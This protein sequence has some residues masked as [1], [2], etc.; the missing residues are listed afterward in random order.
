MRLFLTLA[1][2]VLAALQAPA[3]AQEAKVWR[4]AVSIMGEPKYGPDVKAVDYVNPNA[5]KGGLLRM[6]ANGTFDNLNIV[7][8]RGS[9][10]SPIY[11]I[12]E[13]LMDSTLD[14]IDSEYGHIAEAIS[15]PSDYSS[16]S[17]RLNKAAR[18]HDGKPITVDDVIF[19]FNAFK[20]HSVSVGAYYRDVTK[21]EAT[22]EREV[23]FTF[24]RSGNREL[25]LIVGQL[26]ILPKHWWEGTDASGKPRDISQTSLEIPLGSGAYRVARM[27]PGQSITFERV[28]DWWAK[29]LPHQIGTSNFDEIRY[30]WFRDDRVAFEAFKSGSIDW[31]IE[32]SAKDWATAYDF[33]AIKDGRVL[34]EE[35]PNRAST[36]MQAIFPNM[37]R[38]F[39]ADQR[40]RRALNHV[41]DFE[42]MNRGLM[43]N[44]YK[45]TD[46][47]FVATELAATGLPE[48]LEKTYLEEMK[49]L[50]PPSVFTKPYE[51][52]RGGTPELLRANLREA[53]RLLKEAGYEVRDKKLTDIR[54]GEPVTFELL[55]N[56]PTFERHA[57]Y[58]KGALERLGIAMSIRPVDS[59]QYVNRVRKRDYDL[60]ITSIGQTLNP[61]N[62]Q[63]N[64][65]SSEAADREG[66][67]NFA[68]IKNPAIDKLIDR[69]IL[70]KTR[71]EVVAATRA[72][73]RI[74]LHNDY[75]IPTWYLGVQ[76]AAR[77][78]RF[79]RPA[80][81]P[82]YGVS[83][84]P[85]IWWYD[86]EKAA[87]LEKR[88]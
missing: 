31:T 3:S 72:M 80:E 38:P 20:A 54:T 43:F 76:R 73:D 29:D 36:S 11:M 62:E 9:L 21:V 37:R 5:P 49:D 69:I 60:I 53:L 83:A 57:L 52:P 61:G 88:G 8:T 71:E 67:F 15:F 65:W 70:A 16:V 27:V 25:P 64:Y 77:W 7:P 42:D 45:R 46:S 56:G 85:T 51:N 48:G 74:L 78:D 84:F 58:Y 33:P 14:E 47:F 35:F 32:S 22:G 19:S 66:S 30:E 12:Y 28:K 17:F 86:A 87:R 41:F 4:H 81:L 6:S 39:F 68:G 1:L 79:S 50:V 55:L 82:K 59:S 2:M 10:A 23:T 26:T 44:A 63:R 40:V 34:K 18:F 24:A 13:R 75:V